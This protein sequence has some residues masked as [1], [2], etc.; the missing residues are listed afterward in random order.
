MGSMRAILIAW[1]VAACATGGTYSDEQKIDAAVHRDGNSVTS[2][3]APHSD[4]HLN[5]AFVFHDAPVPQ[6]APPMGGGFC[7]DNTNCIS[8]ECCFVALCV[9][10]T[11]I[12]TSI[13]LPQ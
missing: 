12:G 2:D 3:A 5:D 7:N 4:A 1:F 8:G 11:P 10:G 6:D 9:P 13:C